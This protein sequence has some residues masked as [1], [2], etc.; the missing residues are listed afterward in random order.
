V[1]DIVHGCGYFENDTEF[2]SD[3]VKLFEGWGDVRPTTKADNEPDGCV[4]D[5]L[6]SGECRLGRS[7]NS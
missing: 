3:P 4:L 1:E 6:E 5:P 7:C 2:Y